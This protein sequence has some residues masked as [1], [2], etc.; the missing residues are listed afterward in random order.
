MFYFQI[1]QDYSGIFPSK[2][3]ALYQ[4]WSAFSACILSYANSMKPD[5]KD[6]LKVEGSQDNNFSDGK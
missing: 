3:N 4:K 1:Q 5:W 6:L 2:S